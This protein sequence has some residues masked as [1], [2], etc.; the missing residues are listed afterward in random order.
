MTS[1]AIEL[2]GIRLLGRHGVPDAER[3]SAQPFE[4]DLDVT[5][6]TSPAASSDD[7]ADT[8]DYQSLVQAALPVVTGTTF[9]LL[10]KRSRTP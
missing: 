7:V 3:Q 4:L 8:V 6:D 5:L 1:D 2:R 9:H 10:E